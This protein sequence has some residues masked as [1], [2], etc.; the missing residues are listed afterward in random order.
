MLFRS[1]WG[2]EV[3]A[4]VV[5]T[6]VATPPRLEELREAVKAELPGWYAPRSMELRSGPLPRTALGKIQRNLLG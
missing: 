3:V 4:L 1:Q 5:P 6:D 2:H